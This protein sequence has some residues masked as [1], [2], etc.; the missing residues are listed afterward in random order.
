MITQEETDYC[1]IYNDH[2]SV[3]AMFTE[4]EFYSSFHRSNKIYHN[5][6]N[7]R[8]DQWYTDVGI[9][10]P[11]YP[12]YERVFNVY[13]LMKLIFLCKANRPRES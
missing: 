10:Y 4:S 7:S 3:S 5:D 12:Q 8:Y 1:K 2:A 9:F 13:L 11:Q 6:T